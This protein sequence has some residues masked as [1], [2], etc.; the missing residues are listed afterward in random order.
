MNVHHGVDAGTPRTMKIPISSASN[1]EVV[2]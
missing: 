2:L 1:I